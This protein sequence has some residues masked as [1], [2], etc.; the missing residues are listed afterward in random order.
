MNDTADLLRLSSVQNIFLEGHNV[1]RD[2]TGRIAVSIRLFGTIDCV[3]LKDALFTV[4]ANHEALHTRYCQVEG[5]EGYVCEVLEPSVD[6][7]AWREG[8]FIL[9]DLLSVDMGQATLL[10]CLDNYKGILGLSLSALSA[11]SGTFERIIEALALAYG[12][13]ALTDEAEEPLAYSHFSEWLH[14]MREDE[15]AEEAQAFWHRQ[16]LSAQARNIPPFLINGTCPS[17]QS[18]LCQ[19]QACLSSQQLQALSKLAQ[20]NGSDL[21]K[22]L[23]TVWVHLLIRHCGDIKEEC[24]THCVSWLHDCRQDYEEMENCLGLFARPIPL[25]FDFGKNTD[26]PNAL[27]IL[28]QEIDKSVDWQEF[29]PS[30][31]SGNA[32]NSFSQIAFEFSEI[33][34]HESVC[35]TSF[36]IDEILA[37]SQNY[38][39]QL[40]CI[41]S[42]EQLNFVLS[43]SIFDEKAVERLLEQ[44]VT[45]LEQLLLLPD[46]PLSSLNIMSQSE[47]LWRRTLHQSSALTN[48][49]L[50]NQCFADCVQMQG[51]S[52]AL[53]DA[54][55][56]WTYA[57]LDQ[58]ANQLGN[59][60]LERGVEKGDRVAICLNKS[61]HYVVSILASLKIGACFIPL[62]PQQPEAR[63]NT[64]LAESEA[65][66]LSATKLL[67][68]E[69]LELSAERWIALDSLIAQA[70][71]LDDKAPE[72]TI[73][74]DTVAYMIFT[75]GSTGQPKGV[76]IQHGQ[77]SNY[78]AGA[79]SGLQLFSDQEQR[80][81]HCALSS[82]FIA[83]L[84]NTV[85]FPSLAKGACLHVLDARTCIS[86]NAIKNYFAEYPI[87]C[88]KIVPSHLD[89]LIDDDIKGILPTKRLILGGE[90]CSAELLRKV[91]GVKDGLRVFNH[92][93]PTE[94][95]VGV[96]YKEITEAPGS[97][98]MATLSHSL[99]G[100]QVHVLDNQLKRV[101]TGCVGELYIAGAQLSPGYFRRDDLT[102]ASML[103]NPFVDENVSSERLYC[104]GDLARIDAH[105][106]LCILG[107]SDQQLKIRGFRIEAGEIESL[108]AAHED[109]KQAL[110]MALKQDEM[111]GLVAY[112][113]AEKEGNGIDAKLMQDYLKLR[114]PDYM[115]PNRIVV[116]AALPLLPNGKVDRQRLPKVQNL[117]VPIIAPHNNVEA[118][119]LG[120]WKEMLNQQEIGVEHHFF[121]SGGHSLLAIKT[122]ARLCRLFQMDLPP[123]ILFEYPSVSAMA[124][125]LRAN[126]NEA[127]KTEAMARIRL[128]L[129]SMTP[130]QKA[131]LQKKQATAKLR[132]GEPA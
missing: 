49:K 130:E 105:G 97:D 60:L 40:H 59:Y 30:P 75:S 104:S 43:H 4:L 94:T 69:T 62:E 55:R 87:D 16:T 39:L 81:W 76:V 92:Y 14:D 93:G 21:E 118:L 96:M 72:I 113:V 12:G 79:S 53:R 73:T 2:S 82:S 28:S 68:K 109:I 88:M 29:A 125:F 108:L 19:A 38:D 124:A 32:N 26:L 103:E 36:T 15:S 37:Q 101:P 131:A 33:E 5:I 123:G 83:D 25:S 126:E 84:G 18:S 7:I 106:E 80:Q 110:V 35:R 74:P 63:I 114:L 122:S 65:Y 47:T 6:L 107:R 45:L 132:D 11:D 51:E 116:M 78:I 8:V 13:Q 67:E 115:V 128:Q 112:V 56:T 98:V 100:N 50:F 95:T 54:E 44:Y 61:G 31:T 20:V 77:L 129:Q 24:N 23:L 58:Q 17:D 41:V 120:L 90:T 48:I 91:I 10:A 57:E 27:A 64:I 121:E 1:T 71:S 3:R 66:L 127:G 117:N 9:S 52:I 86:A 42:P 46:L 102:A 85:L 111:E 34:T 99:P 70:D 119:L 22:L 89:A